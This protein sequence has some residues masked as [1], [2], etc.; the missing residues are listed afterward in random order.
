MTRNRKGRAGC[1]QATLNT[2][3]RFRNCT[4]L[5]APIKTM[6]DT[7]A[8]WGLHPVGLAGRLIHRGEPHNE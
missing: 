3:N 8:F 2:S 6:T 5:A 7:M 1:N 4:G